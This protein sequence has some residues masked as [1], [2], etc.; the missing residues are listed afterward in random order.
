M[1][2]YRDVYLK[3]D[4]WKT[5]R[6][7]KLWRENSKCQLCGKVSDH[8]DVHHIKYKRLYDV[9][10]SDLL[11]LCRCCHD[12]VHG[13]LEKYPKLKTLSRKQVWLTILQHFSQPSRVKNAT[14]RLSKRRKKRIDFY[15]R[16]QKQ[17]LLDA[18]LILKWRLRWRD[19]FLEDDNFFEA[20]A[21]PFKFLDYYI[22]K[23]KRD[24]RR[25]VPDIVRP[26]IVLFNTLR[27]LDG[28]GRGWKPKQSQAG[29]IT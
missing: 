10:L 17:K 7:A 2:Y 18:G 20:L 24:P 23:T 11:V 21:C 5:L 27:M 15:Y 4:D 28:F 26:E 14:R 13:L 19:E 6:K 3:S 9:A 25:L 22:V 8:N 1:S 16:N 12:R 29:G